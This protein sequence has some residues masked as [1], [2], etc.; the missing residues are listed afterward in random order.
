MIEELPKNI[1]QSFGKETYGLTIKYR[2]Q[3]RKEIETWINIKKKLDDRVKKQYANS[4]R[5]LG[6][7]SSKGQKYDISS[8]NLRKL[9]ENYSS[10]KGRV[11]ELQSLDKIADHYKKGY[12]M[13]HKIREDLTNQ[14]ITYS[15]MYNNKQQLMEA[16]LTL[17]Q[18]LS[19]A[20]LSYTD[21]KTANIDTNLSNFLN[22][23]IRN[24]SINKIV[25][26]QINKNTQELKSIVSEIDKPDLW[27][28]LVEI[29]KGQN[30]GYVYEVY[31]TLRTSYS[32]INYIGKEQEKL[33]QTLYKNAK[34]N[35]VPGWQ[36]GD[37]GLEQLKAVFNS[38]A[39]LMNVSTIEKTL[40]KID[41]ALASTSEI[42]MI[43]SLS[44]IFTVQI[45]SFNTKLDQLIDEDAKKQIEKIVH[46]NFDN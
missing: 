42:D 33:E 22:L 24:S 26:K 2:T 16:H 38:A 6:R 14:E 29:H 19:A 4:F 15:V 36:A 46:E 28:R 27:D 10:Q 8:K 5:D 7:I 35:N 13:I 40:K 45:N 30:F 18:I 39:N 9:Y 32:K 17:D 23:S 1:I 3:V 31:K 21:V 43:T 11:K 25:K 12:Q 37:I 44:K 34:G 20:K 41:L